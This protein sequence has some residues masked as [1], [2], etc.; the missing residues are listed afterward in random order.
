MVPMKVLVTYQNC[1]RDWWFFFLR[2]IQSYKKCFIILFTFIRSSEKVEG[3]SKILPAVVRVRFRTLILKFNRFLKAIIVSLTHGWCCKLRFL[4]G[5]K[6]FKIHPLRNF[7]RL[8]LVKFIAFKH[9]QIFCFNVV[10]WFL[11][12]KDSMWP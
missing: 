2:F 4:F 3:F 9:Q 5:T 12:M 8:L 1:T 7:S 6:S 10:A 11:K